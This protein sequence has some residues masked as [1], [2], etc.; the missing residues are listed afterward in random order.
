MN[1]IPFAVS[2]GDQANH[3]KPD[4]LLEVQD[5]EVTYSNGNAS[6]NNPP[7]RA[8][9]GVSFQVRKGEVLA[10]V[11]ESGSG[12]TSVARALVRLMKPSRGRI[13]FDGKELA[14]LSDREFQP[15]RSRIQMVFQ[16]AV[17]SLNP[18]MTI[19]ETLS[20]VVLVHQKRRKAHGDVK[21]LLD[22]V[23]LPQ[24]F[25]NRYPHTISG[26]QAQRV[27]IARALAAK[28]EFLVADE[29][30]SALDV[31]IQAQIL[32]LLADLQKDLKLS[33]LF[34]SHDLAVVGHIADRVA[35]MYHGQ[36]V[37]T[38]P[39]PKLYRDAAHH[40]TRALVEATPI[41]DTRRRTHYPRPEI[42][43]PGSL[44]VNSS[45]GCIYYARCGVATKTCFKKK[46]PMEVVGPDHFIRC[47]S[48]VRGS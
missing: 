40:Y 43:V 29:P 18:R 19:G 39:A 48:P 42:P 33:L 5:L 31:S 27:A 45:T 36:V 28:P 2:A 37:E 35:V 14:S 8:V 26:G 20:E 6:P 38:L 47:F 17:A 44:S 7:F 24:N 46:P 23:G 22:T 1:I 32:N 13:V 30:V 10:L 41:P 34:I 3:A 4:L 12:K 16:D 25:A 11:G 21:S 15:Y 9:E